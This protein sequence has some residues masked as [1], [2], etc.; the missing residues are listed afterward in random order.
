MSDY[1]IVTRY[2]INQVFKSKSKY[3]QVNLGYTSTKETNTGDRILNEKDDFA[4]F[5]NNLYRT[6]IQ[7][8]GKIG[9]ISFYTDFYINEDKIAFYY[10]KEEFVFDF[11]RKMV[12][13]KGVDFYLGH[14]IKTINEQYQERIKQEEDRKEQQKKTVGSSDKVFANP[15]N[16]TYADLK[17]YMDRKASERLKS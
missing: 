9:N 1:N 17:A 11:D 4:F 13:E 16:V 7:A 12:D 2:T 5:Y 10:N 3:F 15:G 8:Q 6:T 14:L